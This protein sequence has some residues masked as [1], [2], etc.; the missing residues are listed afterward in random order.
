MT[1]KQIK[2]S[3]E[4][5]IIYIFLILMVLISVGPFVYVVLTAF[6]TQEQIYDPSQI[7]PTYVSF[8]NFVKVLFH[9]NFI[10]YFI[11]SFF[12]SAVTTGIC[13]VLSVMASYALSRYE[14]IGADKIKMS[15]L[16]TRMF[17]GVLLCIPFYIIM[18]QLNL[19]DTHS[20]LIL[21]YCS[22]TLPFAIWR[23]NALFS[24]IPWELEESARIDGCSRLGA[25]FH[26]IIPVARPGLFVNMLFCFMSAWEEY[27]YASIF[28]NTPLKKTI[29]VGMKDFV[30]QYTIEW[31]LLM[32]AVTLSLIPVILF[33]AM[34]QNNLVGGLAEGSVKG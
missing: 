6:K 5:L 4:V 7:I 22:F 30:G 3:I 23:T 32:T 26:V 11:N 31:G 1:G 10:R 20:G 27:M 21:L 17:P 9:S 15:I 24:G 28:I 14:I 19:I 16:M 29:Q 12:V 2:K 25:F 33:F 18:K 8:D 13:V 34:V